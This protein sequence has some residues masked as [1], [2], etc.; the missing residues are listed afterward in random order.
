MGSSCM[1]GFELINLHPPKADV[2]AA[3]RDG[4]R[5]HPRQLPAWLLYDQEGSA[6]FDAITRQPEYSLTRVEQ[7]LLRQE[8]PAPAGAPGGIWCR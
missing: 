6:L 1:N 5:R 2:V 4:L 8:A 3:V 7:A